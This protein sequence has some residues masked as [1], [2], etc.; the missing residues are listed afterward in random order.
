MAQNAAQIAV[1]SGWTGGE[2]GLA[3]A[4]MRI[5]RGADQL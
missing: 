5:E 2:C 4:G 1:E 3:G